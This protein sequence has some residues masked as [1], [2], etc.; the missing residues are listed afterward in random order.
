[1][2][3]TDEIRRR[4]E[5]SSTGTTNPAGLVASRSLQF[6][7][8]PTID[9]AVV[10]RLSA[11]P[12]SLIYEDE[13]G[14][15]GTENQFVRFEMNARDILRG[16]DIEDAEGYR[17]LLQFR[18]TDESV[19]GSDYEE[20]VGDDS[21]QESQDVYIKA[22]FTS[23]FADT[24][25]TLISAELTNLRTGNKY[26]DNWVDVRL[27]DSNKKPL[28]HEKIY[29]TPVSSFTIGIHARRANRLPF[30]LKID[31]GFEILSEFNVTEEQRR[32]ISG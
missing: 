2:D 30:R 17:T 28:D 12:Q 9:R 13:V 24:R 10:Y 32:Y 7:K 14:L 18:G 11:V 23:L 20:A 16:V 6:A 19:E 4:A 1:M 3:V 31:I 5:T 26:I 27:Y 21:V 22:V 29:V 25:T 15:F 8:G